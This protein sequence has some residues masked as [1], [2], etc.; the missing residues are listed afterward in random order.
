MATF[1]SPEVY[2]GTYHK[3]NCGSIKGK[4]V[5]L[6]GHDETTFYEE[7]KALHKDEDDPEFMFQDFQDFPKAFYGESGLDDR[8]WEWLRLREHDRELWSA[9]LE[10]DSSVEFKDAQD[11]FM[12]SADSIED[13]AWEYLEETG[14][15]SVVP[16]FFKTYFD[17]DAY[18]RD[19]KIEMNIVE[20]NGKTWIF[21]Y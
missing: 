17:L 15:F 5:K 18:V 14:Q 21:S 3:Y 4:W 8:I 12:G 7:I 10:Y 2:V 16:E 1:E 11:Q 13:W 19:L 6:E 20:H 9:A